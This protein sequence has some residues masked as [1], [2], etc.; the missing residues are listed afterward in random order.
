M[1][2][3]SVETIL[4]KFDGLPAMPGVALKLIEAIQGAD[5]DIRE[6]AQLISSDA[7]LSAKL[8]KIINS[9]F[10]GL[11]NKITGV[12][13]AVKM[14]GLNAVKN[15]CLGLILKT[16]FIKKG[17]GQSNLSAFWKDALVGAVAAKLLAGQVKIKNVEDAFF[18]GLLANI[19]SLTLAHAFPDQY[20]R[21]P[22]AVET[23]QCSYQEAEYQVFGFDH[24]DVGA[25]LVK[26][27]GLPETVYTPIQY[28]H[29]VERLPDGSSG[30]VQLLTRILHLSSL[31]IDL[32]ASAD[33][34]AVL[35]RIAH[36]ITAYG[37]DG[38]LDAAAVGKELIQQT[39]A[40]SPIFDVQFSDENELESM[41]DN[42]RQELVNI[43]LQMVGDV[44]GKNN[45]LASLR[46]QANVDALTQLHNYKAFREN[47]N[48]EISRSNRYHHPLCLVLADIDFFKRV[49]D[50]LG[51]LAGDQVLKT[52]SQQLKADL[53]ETDFIA[54]HGGEEFAIILPETQL[55]AG[56]QVAERLREQIKAL[57]IPYESQL[58]RVTMSFGVA[59]FAQ[60]PP[61]S[62]EQF[63]KLADDALYVSKNQGRDQCSVAMPS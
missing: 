59:A 1:N 41:L 60:L 44:I 45:E 62:A 61:A 27:W 63:V 17:P 13:Q 28:H 36:F 47:L 3:H 4:Q 57:E 14:L 34:T 54:R 6:I 8:L 20:A 29:C 56:L 22:D 25:L 11:V 31:Y 33:M 53:R 24:M 15:L 42:A 49:N 7:V 48:R 23:S 30:A 38:V 21:V 46:Q 19:G 52:V 32:I 10:Y 50:E 43:S 58:I 37:F 9:P 51:H 40:I 35:G 39:K 2:D 18:L 26:S 5:P 16:R 12:E 55:E